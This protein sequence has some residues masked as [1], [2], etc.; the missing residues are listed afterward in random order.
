MANVILLI[1]VK[2]GSSRNFES[3]RI[4]CM[5]LMLLKTLVINSPKLLIYYNAQSRFKNIIAV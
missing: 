4:L 2:I 1:N 5:L 3:Y